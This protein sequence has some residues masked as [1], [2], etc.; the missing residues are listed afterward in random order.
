MGKF[1]KA[2]T[3][4]ASVI[5]AMRSELPSKG[6]ERTY[7]Q[8]LTRVAEYAKAERIVGGLRGMTVNQA[9]NYLEQRGQE[10][11][12]GK[13]IGQK[14]L[15]IERLGIQAM[16][17]N[18]TGQLGQSDKL[19]MVLSE[20]QQALESRAYTPEQVNMVMLSQSVKHALA[21][22][23]SYHSGARAHE[24]Y[25]LVRASDTQRTA[26]PRPALETK[27][28]ER[29][30]VKYLVDGKGGLTRE[31]MLSKEL[32]ERL[33][34]RKLEAPQLIID[35]DIKYTQRYDI[36]GGKNWSSSFSAAANRSLGWSRGAHGLRHTY[37]QER[38]NEL[39]K[40]GLSRDKALETV[41]QE[42]GHFRSGITEVYLR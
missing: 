29:E 7:E 31:V 19:P 16:M 18:V 22:E 34:A 30:G 3:Q 25:T 12:N 2:S 13:G 33:E 37:A 5:K 9:V 23:V 21:T 36:G 27:F 20:Y 10:V 26:D 15:N 40:L 17:R 38:M 35:R 4:S 39:Q 24:L 32:S 42:L 8:A 14:T 28:K 11:K 1:A 6:S 41:S